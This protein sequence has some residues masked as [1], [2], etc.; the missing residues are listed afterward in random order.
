L[1]VHLPEVLHQTLVGCQ[2]GLPLHLSLLALLRQLACPHLLAGLCLD[3]RGDHRRAPVVQAPLSETLQVDAPAM[4]VLL[5]VARPL[6]GV[7]AVHGR[8]AGHA[9]EG[10]TAGHQLQP[11]VPVLELFEL[12][13]K[14]KR[15]RLFD[16]RP[17]EHHR[18]DGQAVEQLHVGRVDVFV[19]HMQHRGRGPAALLAAHAGVGGRRQRVGTQGRLQPRQVAG[20]QPVVVVEE[21][22]QL[23][24]RMVERPVGGLRP[25]PAASLAFEHAQPVAPGLP[26]QRRQGLRAGSHHQHFDA[27]DLLLGDAGQGLCKARAASAADQ[28]ADARRGHGSPPCQPRPKASARPWHTKA[29]AAAPACG[30]P[31][32]SPR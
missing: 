1:R 13:R 3:Q 5:G 27:I 8:H 31:S 21:Q 26:V 6:C 2:R 25:R 15:R 7:Q 10:S 19:V 30:R 24:A 23:A 4:A 18:M 14:T 9:H 11:E 22:Q 29:S 17:A 28:H 16:A 20:Q 12:I 32:S